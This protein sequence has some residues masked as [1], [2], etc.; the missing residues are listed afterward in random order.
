MLEEKKR[1]KVPKL[2]GGVK[3]ERILNV[4]LKCLINWDDKMPDIV[5]LYKTNNFFH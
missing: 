3:V 4:G 1:I 5:T 2:K